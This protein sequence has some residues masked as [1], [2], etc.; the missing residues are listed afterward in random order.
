MVFNWNLYVSSWRVPTERIHTGEI[1][2]LRIH[3]ALGWLPIQCRKQGEGGY[4]SK[5]P[6]LL[7][8]LTH[9]LSTHALSRA[10]SVSRRL[11]FRTI[12]K[13]C[14]SHLEAAWCPSVRASRTAVEVQLWLRYTFSS[15]RI[16]APGL[17]CPYC[18]IT[19]IL[20]F[21]ERKHQYMYQNDMALSSLSELF[22]VHIWLLRRIAAPRS[23]PVS[24]SLVE[25]PCPAFLSSSHV[26]TNLTTSQYRSRWKPTCASCASFVSKVESFYVLAS[27]SWSALRQRR[28][29]WLIISPPILPH[30]IQRMV[31]VC[32]HVIR[33][34]VDRPFCTCPLKTTKLLYDIRCLWSNI[35]ALSSHSVSFW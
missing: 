5:Q 11:I 10:G 23:A 13:H 29:K 28:R 7:L 19:I 12:C 8:T 6:L 34:Q 33:N 27:S 15:L 20:D 25:M 4:V 30:L 21:E 31:S 35:G 16:R 2:N 9:F 3:D 17:P 18:R 32:I 22:P 26:L 24:S 14:S 1:L